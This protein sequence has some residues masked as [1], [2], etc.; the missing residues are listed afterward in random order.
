MGEYITEFLTDYRQVLLALHIISFVSWMAG[1]LYLPRLFFYHAEIDPGSEMSA[2]FKI[3]E[4]RLLR[5]ITTP[6][7]IATWLFGLL[8]MWSQEWAQLS[9]GWMHAKLLCVVLLTA[10]H[11]HFAATVKKF[12]N[13]A[14][15]RTELYYRIAN[16]VP[17][18]LMII[19]VFMVIVVRH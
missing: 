1:M 18:V 3:M 14:N 7:M 4:H 17:T 11:G 12:R 9:Q 2:M 6:A 10:M 16:E 5:V 13:N 15:D 19:I 8:L